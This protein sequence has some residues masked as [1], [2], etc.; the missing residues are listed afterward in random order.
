MTGASE[1]PEAW[2][3]VIL[4]LLHIRIEETKTD[5]LVQVSR[6]NSF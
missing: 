5:I 4:R 2:L 6:S 1:N 3:L